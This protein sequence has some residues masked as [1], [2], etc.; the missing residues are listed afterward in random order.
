MLEKVVTPLLPGREE[1]PP[2]LRACFNNF[3]ED[4]LNSI[5]PSRARIGRL[6]VEGDVNSPPPAAHAERIL[7]ELLIPERCRDSQ[8]GAAG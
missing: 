6:E 1:L 8:D 7:P 2:H 3:F 5:S 4:L